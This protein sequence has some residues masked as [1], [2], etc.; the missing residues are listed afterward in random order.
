MSRNCIVSPTASQDLAAILDYFFERNVEAGDIFANKFEQKCRKRV[1][2]DRPDLQ[3]LF[4]DS[5]DN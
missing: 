3:S 5:E 4:E 1:K 2:R